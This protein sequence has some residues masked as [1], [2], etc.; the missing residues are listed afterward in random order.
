MMMDWFDLR[1]AFTMG[2]WFLLA[3]LGAF[4]FLVADEAIDA[5]CADQ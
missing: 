4:Y 2:F 1:Q 3:G 5:R